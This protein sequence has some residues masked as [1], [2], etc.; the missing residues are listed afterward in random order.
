MASDK[1]DLLPGDQ[2]ATAEGNSKKS[3]SP[4]RTATFKDYFRVFSYANNWDLIVYASGVVA[5]IGCG[6]T[7]PMMFVMF[8]SF[9]GEFTSFTNGDISEGLDGFRDSLDKLCL[10][11]FALFIARFGLSAI[12]RFAFRMTG[13]RISAA[14]RLHYVRHLFNQTIHVL[15]SLPPGHAVGTITS[16]SNTL[17]IGVSEKLGTF[18]E[19]TSLII[20]SLIVALTWNWELALVT[21]SGLVVIVLIVGTLFPLTVKGQA[22]Q[23]QSEGRAAGLASESFASIRMIMACGAQQQMVDRYG[24][25]IEEAKKHARATIPLTSLQFALTF[26]GVFATVALT[27]WYGTLI[28]T[29]GRLD[30]VGVII[31]V[32]MNLTTIFFSMDRVSAPMQAMGKASLAACEFFSLIDAPAPDRGSL[33]EPQVSAT[34]DIIFGGV[35]FAYP[36]R[37]NVKI[38][39]ELDLRIEA[40]KITAIVGPSGSGKSTIVGLIERWYSLTQQYAIIKAIQD[41]ENKKKKEEEGDESTGVELQETGDA[42]ELRGSVTTC[43]HSLDEI[44]I[45]WWRSQIGLVQQEPFLF[46]DTIYENVARGLIGSRWEEEPE[47]VKRGLVKKACQEAF[48]DEFIDKLPQGYDTKVGDGGAGLSGGQRQRL[49]IARS[50]VKRPSIL[51][52]DEATS[53]IDVRGERIVQEALNKAAQGR[54]TIIIAHRLS[55]IKNADRIVVLKKGKVVESGTHESLISADGVYAGLVNAQALSSGD[56][57]EEDIYDGFDT[58][59]MDTLSREKSHAVSEYGDHLQSDK[60]QGGKDRGFFGSFGRFFFESKTYW[61]LMIFSFIASI[62][63]G[64]AQPLYAWIFSRSID[65]FKYQDDHSKLMDKVDFMGIMWTVFAASA[66]IAYYFTFISSGRVASFIRAKYQTQYFSS[67]I[68]QRAAYFDEDGHSHGT[69]V[70]R[71]RD[72]P[73]KL[74][75]MMGTN[76]AQVCIAVFNVI[77]GLLM[78]LVYSWKL[79]LVSMAAVTP[80]CVFSGYLRFRY[81]LQF[82]RMNDEVFAESSQFA[83]EAINAFR[84]VSSLTLEDSISARF[85]KL[86]HGHVSSAFKKARW[87]SIILGFSDSATLGCQALIFYYGGR[88]LT[89]GEIG[90]MGFFVCLM[91]MMNAAEG[92]GQSLSFGPNAAQAAAASNRILDARE[93]HLMEPLGK[94]DI[95]DAEGGITI[96]L[97][98]VRLRYAGRK[99]P[100][101]NGLNM[102]IEKGQFVALVGASGCGKTS[103]ISL[104]ERLYQPEKGQ[105]LCNGKDISDV[106]IYTYRKHLSLVAQEPTLFQGTLRDN[107]LLGIDPSTI[108]DDQLHAACRD[109]SIHDFIASLPEGYN[110]NIG[111]RGVSLSGGQKQ[112]VSIARALIRN[113]Q[114]L[115]LDEATSSLDSESERLVQAAFERAAKG[116]TMIAVAHRL[117]TVQN[118]DVIY[119]FGEGGHVLEKGSH[120]QLLKKRGVYYQICQNQALD[121]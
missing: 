119:V 57:S 92:F 6:V 93:S 106:N 116:R 109:A 21:L 71:V 115:L 107:I 35:T 87:V 58:E 12:H 16:S 62:A 56:S 98:D 74:E 81:E 114:V 29:K 37:P 108:T 65:L 60:H 28:F 110:T 112:R 8:G 17:Q 34:D 19:Y 113:P 5:A 48:A 25:S 14:I 3:P 117:A 104:L 49:A 43:G 121:Q 40:G 120:G 10:Y 55:T 39:D 85:E 103:I 1:R 83:S 101:L 42:V 59:D 100:V 4:T 52:L 53:A 67:L 111:S 2:A 64:T 70:S 91:A 68:F 18:I 73:L 94:G 89:Q 47:E 79:G 86:C 30:D 15:D 96:E 77:G 66:A 105:I 13:I 61:G 22:R 63:A 9:V 80:V 23:A 33:R 90:V 88:L 72:D 24:A 46:N 78:A 82:E 27:F 32:L 26:F 51:I 41:E 54:T 36:S 45:K 69:L 97:R 7:T 95:P 38:L 44:D 31:V 20:A 11:V 84:T 50:I 99:T 76:I 75:E 118:A 102:T